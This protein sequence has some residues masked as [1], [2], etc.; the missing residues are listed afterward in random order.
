MNTDFHLYRSDVA[1]QWQQLAKHVE[2]D[3]S[4][5]HLALGNIQRWLARGR[6][7]PAP[8]IE[9]QRRIQMAQSSTEGMKQL[10]V[11]LRADN[12]DAETLKSCSPFAGTTTTPPA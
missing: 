8:L 3:P 11:F 10:L 7:H 1:T 6:L 12:A 9:W 5:L 2:S 4:M